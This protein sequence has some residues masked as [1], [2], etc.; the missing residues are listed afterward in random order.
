MIVSW[1]ESDDKPRQ[2]VE[3]QRL[4]SANKGPH[5]QGYGLPSGHVHLWELN[6]KEGGAQRIMP[7]D[8]GAGETP[9]SPLDSKIKPVSLKGNQF[10]ILIRRTDAWA[11]APVFW[12]SNANSGLIGK[13]PEAGKDWGQEEKRESEDKKSG[14]H[15]QHDGHELGQTLGG[16][17]GQGGC[18]WD[19]LQT[20]CCSPWDHRV[21]HDWVTEQQQWADKTAAPRKAQPTS[22]VPMQRRNKEK[23]FTGWSQGGTENNAQ[24]NSFQT[25][26]SRR[27]KDPPRLSGLGAFTTLVQLDHPWWV[28]AVSPCFTFLNGTIL[29][30]GH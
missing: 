11:E 23:N 13:V 25:A 5:S 21:R 19:R 10:W 28:M 1:Q 2:C 18:P 4:Y 6:R 9:E 22:D 7:S 29:F 12:S 27:I 20:M 17:G 8:C 15:H 3:K 24:K 26:D 14:W 16:G 30:G